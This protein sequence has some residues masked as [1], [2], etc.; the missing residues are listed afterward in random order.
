MSKPIF[1]VAGQSNASRVRHKAQLEKY[2]KENGIDAK[3]VYHTPGGTS[4]A[5]SGGS[6]GTDNDW[7]PFEDGRDDTGENV[8][9][10]FDAID[11]TLER[12]E[13]S[14]VA[15]VLWVQGEADGARSSRSSEYFTNLQ[16]LYQLFTENYGEEVNFTV[17]QL[18]EKFPYFSE[19]SWAEP[20][21]KQVQ[22]AQA[23][24]ARDYENVTLI[25]PGDLAKEAGL[26]WDLYR[27]S[28]PLGAREDGIHYSPPL[29]KLVGKAFMDQFFGDNAA[30]IKR[31]Y[32]DED[33]S[34]AWTRYVDYI[35]LRSDELVK[36]VYEMDDG[37]YKTDIFA[38]GAIVL[39]KA[40]DP[41]DVASWK[42]ITESYDPT[43]AFVTSRETINDD[44]TRELVKFDTPSNEKP[45]QSVTDYFEFGD[46]LV[47]QRVTLMD[48]GTSV[49][50]DFEDGVLTLRV[51][52][53]L[54]D[55]HNWSSRSK[56]FDA[57]G[58]QYR[59]LIKYDDG[60]SEV[61]RKD[62]DDAK[63]WESATRYFDSEGAVTRAIFE[64]DSG[65]KSDRL[66]E[67]GKP[68]T[69]ILTDEGD[70]FDWYKKTFEFDE[71]EASFVLVDV[72]W[73]ADIA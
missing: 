51:V 53:D 6:G 42:E 46:D 59:T 72:I 11:K 45:W 2:L 7:Y 38:D 35:D 60:T 49:S 63:N 39:S 58:Q 70:K 13:G 50:E 47:D 36:R 19:K 40:T 4:L 27:K 62:V 31:S 20:F 30:P 73:D 44:G 28:N 29:A 10:L 14:Y 71:D 67:D 69:Q 8:D 26:N 3:I 16:K 65:V 64:R 23:K 37:T 22:D 66:F 54:S 55:E 17:A 9:I 15:G 57:E 32:L 25:D 5:A 48:T 12:E 21:K 56:Y 24:L 34:E 18:E 41:D 61:R 1:V 33:G 68:A 52:R 43:G